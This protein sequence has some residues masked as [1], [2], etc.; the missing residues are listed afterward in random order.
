MAYAGYLLKIGNYTLPF[1]YIKAES[2][3]VFR[4]VTDLDSYRDANGELHRTALSH[5]VYK[6]EFETPAMLTNDDV[7]SLMAHIRDNYIN[8]AERKV[9]MTLY[10]PETDSYETQDAYMPDPQFTIYMHDASQTVPVL[11][12][13]PIRFAFIGY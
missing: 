7:A 5:V 2:Y 11:K 8:E 1:K 10:I 6:C 4:S 12:Y 9:V 13:N 3:K